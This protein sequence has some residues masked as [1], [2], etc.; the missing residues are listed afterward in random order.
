MEQKL[1]LKM[2]SI[3]L[4]HL[5]GIQKGIQHGHSIDAMKIEFPEFPL[6]KQWL[7][8]DK[9]VVVLET[10]STEE[11]RDAMKELLDHEVPAAMF[12]EPALSNIPTSISF[13]AD[14]RVW[15]MDLYPDVPVTVQLPAKTRKED[16]ENRLK[17]QVGANAALIG[18]YCAWLR[19]FKNKFRLASN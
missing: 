3:V 6:L 13:L 17:L 1:R 15:D 2:Y 4:M 16:F 7:H 10:T 9:T 5:S 19:G 18:P 8:E 11:L 14:E 12:F